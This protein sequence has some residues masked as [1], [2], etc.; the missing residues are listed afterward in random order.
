MRRMATKAAAR[1]QLCV[2]LVALTSCSDG[3]G[4]SEVTVCLDRWEAAGDTC[5]FTWDMDGQTYLWNGCPCHCATS[6][7]IEWKVKVDFDRL[8]E[9]ETAGVPVAE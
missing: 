6:D 7:G 2:F 8:S 3:C 9:C 5:S 1:L 4:G